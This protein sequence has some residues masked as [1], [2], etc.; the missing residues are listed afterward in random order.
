[1]KPRWIWLTLAAQLLFFVA[2]GASEEMKRGGGREFLLETE[3]VDPRDLLSG[4]YM[5]LNVKAARPAG[6]SGHAGPVAVRLEKVGDAQVEGG[7]SLP[8]WAAAAAQPQE[9]LPGPWPALQ[10]DSGWAK[11]NSDGSRVA[12]GIERY[13]FSQARGQSLNLA[14][15]EFY[16]KVKLG[17]KGDLRVLD[18]LPK[19]KP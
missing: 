12:Y 13:Y 9:G 10:A 1:M 8:L 14:P 5:I 19:A 17:K 18:L 6:L 4:Q 15:G 2:W 11:G 7:L 16:V 3:R